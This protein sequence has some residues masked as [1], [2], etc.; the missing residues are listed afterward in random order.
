MYFCRKNSDKFAFVMK[1]RT[2]IYLI[3]TYMLMILCFNCMSVAI[4]CIPH[5]YFDENIRTSLQTLSE[6]GRFPWTMGNILWGK[7][8]ITDGSMYNIAISGYAMN[9][10]EEAIN[11]PWSYPATDKKVHTADCGLKAMKFKND[12]VERHSYGRYWHGYQVPLR[13]TS[14]FFSIK[15]QRIFHSIVLWS[16][17]LM[18]TFLLYKRMGLYASMGWFLSLLVVGFPAVPLSLQYVACYYIMFGTVFIMLFKTKWIN[19]PI[20]FFIVG[21]FTSYMD[22]LTV[23]LITLCIPLVFSVLFDNEEKKLSKLATLALMWGI[24]YFGIWSAKWL[25]QYAYMGSE[26]VNQVI[27]AGEGHT[28]IPFLPKGIAHK[29]FWITCILLTA[30]LL[31]EIIIFILVKN[32]TNRI[33][34]L[35]IISLIPFVWYIIFL[36]HNVCHIWFTY[37]SLTTTFYCSWL[38]MFYNKLRFKQ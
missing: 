13:I 37:R 14:I 26:A 2:V 3:Y 8:N 16:C 11:N 33:K 10:I 32:K 19:S 12:I 9:P 36:G 28:I 30:A 35:F 27:Y 31:Y 20:L 23:P 1:R 5:K 6:E 29:Y 21:G 17:F 24:G 7:D 4:C 34:Q 25:I 15:G 18:L 38:I 22:Y